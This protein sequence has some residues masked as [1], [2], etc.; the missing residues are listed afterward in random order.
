MIQPS[1]MNKKTVN[2]SLDKRYGWVKQGLYR[3]I[4][5][6]IGMNLLFPLILG[7]TLTL[8]KALITTPIWIMLGFVTGYINKLM[9]DEN[10]HKKE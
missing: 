7:E 5:M 8:G 3:G 1:K 9:A 6:S 10:K 2:Q 4:F